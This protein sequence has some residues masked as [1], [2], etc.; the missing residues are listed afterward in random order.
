MSLADASL[1]EHFQ[2]EREGYFCLDS[3]ALKEGK[4]VFNLTV[5]LRETKKAMV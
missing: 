3:K 5:A 2:F 1:G 4:K